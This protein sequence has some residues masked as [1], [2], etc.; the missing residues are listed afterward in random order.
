MAHKPD[1]TPPM[2]GFNDWLAYQQSMME[3]MSSALTQ[4][5]P[6]APGTALPDL[7]KMQE[8]AQALTDAWA[9]QARRAGE[10]VAEMSKAWGAAGGAGSTTATAAPA[11]PALPTLADPALQ[12]QVKEMFG[13][14]G[15]GLDAQK[16]PAFAD[17]LMRP[18]MQVPACA[19]LRDLN[20][21]LMGLL[22][23]WTQLH[24][25]NLAYRTLLAQAWTG[26]QQASMQ[27]AFGGG[28][29]VPTEPADWSTGFDAWLGDVH[30]ALADL[31]QTADY[32]KARQQMV[33]A[34]AEVRDQLRR[35][36]DDLAECFQPTDHDEL[37]DVTRSVADLRQQLHRLT[38]PG[39]GAPAP[40]PARGT[41]SRRRT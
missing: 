14:F 39:A 36:G 41:R 17:A 5:T 18:L 11:W 9:A 19:R 40:A 33:A 12:Q 38:Q 27:R 24:T 32:R 13:K 3:R 6:G 29:G 30:A 35:L 22:G 7:G 15:L 1:P 28:L 20:R 31:A 25:A 26:A 37:D 34:G 10:V 23:A 21:M 4:G 8:Q 16:M 2:H